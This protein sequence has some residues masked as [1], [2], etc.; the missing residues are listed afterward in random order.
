MEYRE[1]PA[2]SIVV[3]GA[4]EGQGNENAPLI[5]KERQSPRMNQA[6]HKEVQQASVNDHLFLGIGI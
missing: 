2:T 6:N 5:T 4:Q 1:G 3:S